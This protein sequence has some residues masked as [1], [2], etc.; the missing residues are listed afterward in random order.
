MPTT[1][2]LSAPLRAMYFFLCC[3]YDV[4]WFPVQ[5]LVK[6]THLTHRRSLCNSL[7]LAKESTINLSKQ[8]LK[9]KLLAVPWHLILKQQHCINVRLG[10]TQI[11]LFTGSVKQTNKQTKKSWGEVKASF[12]KVLCCLAMQKDLFPTSPFLSLLSL[13]DFSFPCAPRVHAALYLWIT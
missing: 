4:H 8:N 12:V 11:V 5:S 6:W 13:S 10:L 2:H 9:K 7:L 3:W 1:N